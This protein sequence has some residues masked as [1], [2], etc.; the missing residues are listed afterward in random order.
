[1]PKRTIY[2]GLAR[3]HWQTTNTCRSWGHGDMRLTTLGYAIVIPGR[4]SVF[5]AGFQP[6]SNREKFKIG[7]AAGLRPAGAPILMFSRP[8]SGR[9][10]AQKL[11][12]RH[13]STS[14]QHHMKMHRSTTFDFRPTVG[15]RGLV[16]GLVRVRAPC[17]ARW[18]RPL[19][20]VDDLWMWLQLMWLQFET[21]RCPV[22]V[23]GVDVGAVWGSLGP[24]PAPN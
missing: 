20:H 14:L 8:T 9:N 11:D 16:R 7:H 1:M 13:G 24:K 12:C 22:K 21:V 3:A 5:R 19:P 15:L 2:L 4:K 17:K 6:D 10:P 18:L 23:V